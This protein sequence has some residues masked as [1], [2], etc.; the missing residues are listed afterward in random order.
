MTNLNRFDGRRAGKSAR[1]QAA[2][3]ERLT[4]VR[5]QNLLGMVSVLFDEAERYVGAERVAGVQE[6]LQTM[7][8][9]RLTVDDLS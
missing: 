8:R 6:I 5:Y 3:I 2:K 9:N 1:P 4:D 7:T